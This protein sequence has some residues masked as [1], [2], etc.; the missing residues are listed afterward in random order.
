MEV[1][2]Q[3]APLTSK[4]ST[5]DASESAKTKRYNSNLFFLGYATISY[6][7]KQHIIRGATKNAIGIIAAV[8][9]GF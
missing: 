9:F 8:I 6:K 1:R 4:L 7:R 5:M 3:S 2:L